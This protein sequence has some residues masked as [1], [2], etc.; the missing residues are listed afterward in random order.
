MRDLT[1]VSDILNKEKDPSVE[2]MLLELSMFGQPRLGIYGISS[3]W[4]CSVHVFVTGEGIQFEVKSSFS[5]PTPASAIKECMQRL[6]EALS[7]L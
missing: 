3:G 7:K 1:V 5:H 2:M 4:H 6:Y